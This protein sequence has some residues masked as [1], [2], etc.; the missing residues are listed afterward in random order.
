MKEEIS[1]TIV[2]LDDFVSKT[3]NGM[4]TIQLDNEYELFDGS[5]YRKLNKYKD[6]I[7]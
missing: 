3:H 6:S 4:N 2:A 1:R 5:Q 7:K